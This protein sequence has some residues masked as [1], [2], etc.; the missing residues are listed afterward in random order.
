MPQRAIITGA[1]SGIGKALAEKLISEGYIVGITGRRLERLEA[2]RDKYPE[3]VHIMQMDVSKVDKARS[4]FDQL[5]EQMGGLDLCIVNAGIGRLNP[6]FALDPE[7]ETIEVNITGFVA[8]L[9]RAAD[10]FRS[11]GRGHIVGISSIAALLGNPGSPAYNASKA[12]VLNYLEGV[13]VAL[14]RSNITVTDIRPGFV[15]S[16]LTEKNKRMFWVA[17]AEKAAEQIYRA[18]KRKKRYAYITRRWRLIAWLIYLIPDWLRLRFSNY[19][20]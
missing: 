10:Y 7:L 8:I 11:Q 2:M 14:R 4:Q 5:V 15:T 17:P 1:S 13:Y 3:Q 9:Q 12:F 6:E 16:E 18:I 19:S 20:S